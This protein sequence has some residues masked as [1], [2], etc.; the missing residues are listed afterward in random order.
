MLPENRVTPSAVLLDRATA[1]AAGGFSTGM[2]RAAD[3]DLWVRLLERGTGVIVPR[4]TVIYSVHDGQVT[5]DR[6]A[7]RVATVDLLDRYASAGWSTVA[8]RRRREG[9]LAWDDLRAAEDL[10][11]KLRSVARIAV[12]PRRLQGT[13][14]LL[15]ARL[16]ARRAAARLAATGGP[17][18][19]LLPG[20][21]ADAS[22]VENAIDLRA[23]GRVA[24][25]AHVVRRPPARA[26]AANRADAAVLRALGVEVL[27]PTTTDDRHG[28]AA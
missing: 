9:A 22:T 6:A 18:V 26:V 14:H 1:L 8:V 28:S 10:R 24:A 11:P 23:R 13:F 17:S 15:A 25:L 2:P 19:A 7:M 5:T 20:S 21:E 4:A 12:S 16:L 27:G 3:L